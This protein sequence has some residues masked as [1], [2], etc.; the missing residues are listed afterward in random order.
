MWFF[1]RII[2]QQTEN[3]FLNSVDRSVLDMKN[4]CWNEIIKNIQEHIMTL[5]TCLLSKEKSTLKSRL[6]DFVRYSGP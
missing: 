3:L 6:V 2:G 1:M 5:P 4:L